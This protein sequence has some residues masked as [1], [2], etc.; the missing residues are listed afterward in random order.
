MRQYF[1]RRMVS[2]L[3]LGFSS[4]LPLALITS[5]LQAWYTVSGVSIVAI[6]WLTLV[7]QPYA[8]KFLWAPL[9]DRWQPLRIGRRRSWIL[10]MQFALGATFA[11]MSFLHPA[12]TPALL[13]ILAFLVALFSSTQDT[14]IDAY[15]TELLSEHERGL[16][17]SA[18]T[19][20]YRIAMMASG[21]LA[22]IIAS[23]TNWQV[24]YLLMS[25]C[26]FGLM[27][28]TWRAPNPVEIHTH[29]LT[30]R[31]AMIAPLQSFFQ[32]KHACAIL[33]F[34]VIYKLCDAMALSL[35]TTFLIRGVGFSLMQVGA[36]SKTAGILALLIGSVLGGALM[37]R[38]SLYRALWIFGFLQMTSNLLYAWLAHVGNNLIVMSIAIFGENFCSALGTIAFIVFLMNLCDRRYTA[39]QYAL[40]AAVSSLGRIFIGP[41]SA[42][43]VKQMGWIDFYILSAII[44][45]P[46][47]GILFYLRSIFSGG[48]EEASLLPPVSMGSR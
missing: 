9:L 12:K 36:I 46:S 48:D 24:M 31:E 26:F 11:A 14:A 21:A 44:G 30:L 39:T 18:N 37:A 47:L 17:V 32:K 8:Y 4:G 20:A 27:L 28:T 38:M 10:L 3:F 41:L 15:R 19:V 35:N 22:L 13:A 5:T 1:N 45:L 16:G 29:H 23:K 6:G 40:F 25:G 43:I 7:G 33:I 42:I 34:I 2:I